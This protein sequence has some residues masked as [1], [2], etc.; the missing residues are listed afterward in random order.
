KRRDAVKARSGDIG[1]ARQQVAN[2]VRVIAFQ[3]ERQRGSEG[4]SG[5]QLGAVREQ[6]FCALDMSAYGG[7]DE[8][9]E[10]QEV[11]GVRVSYLL[12]QRLNLYNIV[13]SDGY[14]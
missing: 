11:S 6:R 8:R 13:L 10:R 9:R 14:K 1:V 5:L 3:S 2:H 7:E 12:Q 4:A